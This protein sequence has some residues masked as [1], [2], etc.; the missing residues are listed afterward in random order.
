MMD[1]EDER[2]VPLSV[3]A[4]LSMVREL[5]LFWGPSFLRNYSLQGCTTEPLFP[6]GEM[7]ESVTTYP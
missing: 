4:F 6:P 7:P 2:K 1:G 3:G 5:V